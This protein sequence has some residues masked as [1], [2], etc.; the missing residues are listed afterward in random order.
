MS[1]MKICFVFPSRSRPTKFFN[2]L[3]N[4]RNMS[5][6]KN[7]FILVKL[8]TDDHSMN[9]KAIIEQL[10]NEYPEVTVKW[11]LSR[12]K[13]DAINRSMEDLPPCDILVLQSDDIIWDVWGFD[14]E[15]RN[16]FKKFFPDLS[17]T[18]HFPDDHGKSETSIVSILG[19]NLYKRLGYLY[20]PRFCSVY[21]DNHFT[22]MTKSIG[23]HV[24]V[25]KRLF[26]HAHPIWGK[27]P[28]DEQYKNSEAP[29]VYK[30]DRETFFDLKN[31]NFGL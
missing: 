21:A 15:I 14:N 1:E 20:H 4:I 27:V 16:A 7:Y 28:W 3:D 23:K 29:D 10:K 12:N 5:E 26:T 19:I 17:G 18:I 24:F 22:E 30:K 25:K 9:N 2:T 6:S 8:D 13:V 11:G 31:N